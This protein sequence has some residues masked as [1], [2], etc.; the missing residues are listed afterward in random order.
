MSNCTVAG[1]WDAISGTTRFKSDQEFYAESL[2]ILCD[3]AT[4]IGG[5]GG[6]SGV[7]ILFTSGVGLPAA[8]GSILTQGYRDITNPNQP[9]KYINTAWPNS[10]NPSWEAI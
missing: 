8:D 7:G 2:K 3:V 1:V 10:A 6:G 5:G 9:S 4:M